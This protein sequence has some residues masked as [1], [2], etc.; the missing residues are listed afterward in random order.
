[1]PFRPAGFRGRA[2]SDGGGINPDRYCSYIPSPGDEPP[3][4]ASSRWQWEETDVHLEHVGD[5]DAAARLLLVHGAGGNAA[6][7][8]P[9]AS[10]LARLGI[11]VTVPDLPGYGLT[12][13]KR[14][15]SVRYGDWRRMLVD[16][17]RR[18]EDGRPLIIMGASMGGM[19]AYDAAAATGLASALVV[20]C[21][22]DPRDEEVRRCLTWHPALAGLAG[23]ALRVLAGPLG[24]VR[25]PLAWIANMRRIANDQQ[26]VTEVLAD[27]RGGGGRVPLGWMR[28]FL[29]SKPVMEPE[30]F[31]GPEVLMVHPG[32]DRWTPL[33]ASLAFFDRIEAP[34][35]LAVLEQCGHFPIEEPG[36]QQMLSAII[37]LLG[38]LTSPS[39]TAATGC[40]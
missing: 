1:M 12:R 6:A 21:L 8:W 2:A 14:P 23:P 11:Y 28:S 30:R 15:G 19:L 26:L 7:M 13:T 29:E 4:R 34:K 5:A 38:R 32:A 40:G 31:S 9:F 35:T 27:K 25:L 17:V 39:G 24:N 33:A 20:T 36:F 37:Q 18:E 16:L 10:H 3:L 22:L